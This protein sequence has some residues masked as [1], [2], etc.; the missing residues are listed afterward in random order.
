M[1]RQDLIAAERYLA[2]TYRREAAKRAKRNPALAGRL[3]TWAKAS[4]ARAEE[5]RCGPLFGADEPIADARAA[6]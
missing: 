1:N 5:M 3:L 4:D 6:A 2:A